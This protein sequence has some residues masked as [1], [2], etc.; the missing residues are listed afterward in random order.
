VLRVKTWQILT[1]S[2]GI[3]KRGFVTNPEETGT[4]AS[5]T[6]STSARVPAT[7]TPLWA[8]PAVCR[9]EVDLQRVSSALCYTR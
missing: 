7:R 9:R 1:T 3:R 4:K 6:I 2:R 8:A 5:M